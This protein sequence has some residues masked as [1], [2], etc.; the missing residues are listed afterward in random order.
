MYRIA[1]CSSPS[2]ACAACSGAHP[3]PALCRVA[4]AAETTP[5]FPSTPH[6]SVFQNS[7]SD[8]PFA[9]SGRS[10]PGDLVPP[11]VRPA[12]PSDGTRTSAVGRVAAAGPPSHTH[13]QSCAAA[14]Q[15]RPAIPQNHL[16][17]GSRRTQ[18]CCSGAIV[19]NVPHDFAESIQISNTTKMQTKN[20]RGAP[21][22]TSTVPS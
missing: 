10:L 13:M 11:H 17:R 5:M 1:A 18:G 19:V 8:R 12:Y 2:A 6:D 14:L 9:G 20:E 4:C 16:R 7:S 15:E 3:Q 21:R 22:T